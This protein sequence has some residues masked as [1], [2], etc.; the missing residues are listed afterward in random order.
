MYSSG[1]AHQTFIKDLVCAKPNLITLLP[2]HETVISEEVICIDCGAAH[3]LLSD[4]VLLTHFYVS[5]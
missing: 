4:V 5:F 1:K 3:L 2:P